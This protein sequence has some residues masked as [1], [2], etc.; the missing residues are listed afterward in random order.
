VDQATWLACDDPHK[1]LELLRANGKLSDRKARLFAVACCRRIWPLLTDARTRKAVEVAER[2]ADGTASEQELSA[3]KAHTWTSAS[4]ADA[5][6]AG[7]AAEASVWLDARSASHYAAFAAACDGPEG[8]NPGES[9]RHRLPLLFR[10][11]SR[12]SSRATERATQAALLRDLCGPL[13]FREV[14]LDL[15]WLTWHD[16]L[17]VRLAQAAYDERHLPAG[18]LDNARLAVFADALEEADCQDV[19][20]LGHLRSGG[21]H[22]R[23]CFVIDLL[24][25]KE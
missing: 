12:S 7:R 8:H 13:L 23:G 19:Q 9:A 6:A 20:I 1:M 5:A 2:Y 16:G 15:A 25:G 14:H 17:V 11:R 10:V 3:A 18:T 4:S 22:V 21:D 24:L